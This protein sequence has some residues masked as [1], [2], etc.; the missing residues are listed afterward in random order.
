MRISEPF[1]AGTPKPYNIA[2]TFFQLREVSGVQAGSIDVLFRK[3]SALL[4]V[5]L[6]AA[7]PGDWVRVPD[8]FD[9]VEVVSSVAQ[10]VA[11]KVLRGEAGSQPTIVSVQDG[12]RARSLSNATFW[13]GSFQAA[14]AAQVSHMQLWNPAGSGKRILLQQLAAMCG[15]AGVTF[16]V[17]NSV[18]ALANLAVTPNPKLVGGVVS[19]AE[20]RREANAASLGVGIASLSFGGLGAGVWATPFRLSNPAALLPGSGLILLTAGTVNALLQTHW[21]IDEETI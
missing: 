14:V 11:F 6:K 16:N 12:G 13:G 3:G 20:I 15:A 18:V 10:T 7:D 19:V 17:F 2:G 8:G 5:D 4:N 9:Y 1:L 21:E